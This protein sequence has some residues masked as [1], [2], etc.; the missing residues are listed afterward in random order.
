MVKKN[1]VVDAVPSAPVEANTPLPGFENMVEAQGTSIEEA[2]TLDETVEFQTAMT[3]Y[4][5]PEKFDSDDLLIP[6]LRLA[7]G[8]TVEVQNGTAKPG[9]WIVTGSEPK[10]SFTVVPLLYA[11]KRRL[12]DEDFQAL[13][14]SEDSITGEGTP[15][16]VCAD[17]PMNKWTGEGKK[18]VPPQC[19]FSYSYLV[20]IQETKSLAIID[21]KR[22]SIQSGKYI[23]TIAAQKGLGK[24]AVKLGSTGVQAKKGS[25]YAP[26]ITP[27]ASNEEF[28]EEARSALAWGA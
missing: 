24:F 12:Q 13:C 10:E 1:T 9:Q 26:S 23:N 15:G 11:R 17:C 7:Q 21:F 22:T 25:F 14:V 3:T 20:Y 5:A 4:R 19:V 8:L 6:R 27:V 18:R 2:E 28:L 16:G